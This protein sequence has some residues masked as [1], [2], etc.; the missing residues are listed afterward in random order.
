MRINKIEISALR[1]EAELQKTATQEIRNRQSCVV[2]IHTD[3]GLVGIG[4]AQRPETPESMA[5]MIRDIF[6]PLLLGND[7]TEW[8]TLWNAMYSNQRSRGR[9][10]GFTIEAMSAIDIALWDL[11]SKAARTPIYKM[12][13]GKYHE[14]LRT[15]AT[16]V[17]LGRPREQRL[18]RAIEFVEAGFTAFKVAV[19]T[20]PDED[21]VFLKELRDQLGFNLD[22]LLDAN[23]SLSYKR[24]LSFAR[25]LEKLEIYW[26]EEPM[27]PEFLD[28]YV[29]LRRKSSI[30]IAA[31]ESEFTVFGF[32]DWISK[33][34]LDIVQP[35]V[36]RAG[37]I[38]QLTK[39][40][41]MAEAFGVD[42]APH[43]GHG[44]A[45]TYAATIPVAAS[46][47]N[48][49]MFELEQLDNPMRERLTKNRLD[50]QKNGLLDIGEYVG[51][52][53]ELDQN[54]LGK[55]R[56]LSLTSE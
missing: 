47:I 38:T 52:G 45:L 33:G 15:Y 32:K 56:T 13:G 44:S 28:D 2:E 35:D 5:F 42:F 50:I 54:F 53:V 55:N 31:G 7:P 6:A 25:A 46:A 30:P 27:S 22:I 23:C 36:G 37:G 11:S 20:D 4:D 12:L 1:S 43:T 41:D 14:K 8:E 3:E 49:S 24:A 40:A 10:K 17:M 34:A 26:L 18:K 48:F 29:E 51:I 9:T 16:K 19:G 39:I 21:L